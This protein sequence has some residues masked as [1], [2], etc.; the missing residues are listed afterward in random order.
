PSYIYTLS[1]HDALPIFDPIRAYRH[2]QLLRIVL[3]DALGLAK[4]GAIFTELSDLAEACLLF[5]G[6]LLGREQLTIIALG[7]FG[8]REISYRS[9]EHTSELQSRGHLV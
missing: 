9:E 1:L 7:K 6:K 8:G 3:R 2:R 5:A 4:P